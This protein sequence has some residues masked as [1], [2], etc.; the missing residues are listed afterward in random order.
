MPF[1]VAEDLRG[2]VGARRVDASG[3][4]GANVS[5]KFAIERGG[6]MVI[7]RMVG[8]RDG[9]RAWPLVAAAGLVS[10]V[11]AGLGVGVAVRRDSSAE[12]NVRERMP[13]EAIGEEGLL[14]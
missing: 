4:E 14:M 3:E 8:S 12:W 11:G 6:G 5:W 10:G 1:I 2:S 9:R 13:G 7:E